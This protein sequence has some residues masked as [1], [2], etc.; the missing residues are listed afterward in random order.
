LSDHKQE[1]ALL[2]RILQQR[3]GKG[4]QNSY[5]RVQQTEPHTGTAPDRTKC[6]G[7]ASE[8]IQA[9]DTDVDKTD[10]VDRSTPITSPHTAMQ[11]SHTFLPACKPTPYS[12]HITST[13]T[14]LPYTT[15]LFFL[16]I[17]AYSFS[18]PH[19]SC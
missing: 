16:E 1:T 6:P 8:Y 19:A 4:Q 12:I 11:L 5:T 10:N 9:I 2:H 7:N 15:Q 18:F 17:N 3:S 14:D 13:L